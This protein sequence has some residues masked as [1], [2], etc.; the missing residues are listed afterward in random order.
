MKNSFYVGWIYTE[1]SLNGIFNTHRFFI[2]RLSENFNKVVFIDLTNFKIKTNFNKVELNFSFRDKVRYKVPKNV[3]FFKPKTIKELQ[4][5]LINKNFVS[6]L[7]LGRNFSDFKIHYI[8]SKLKMKFV[9][10]SYLGNL[11]TKQIIVK[12]KL[13]SGIKYYL[14]KNISH[15][16]IV[17]FSNFGIFPKLQI[18]F[19]TD[20]SI[21][22][23]IKKSF[24]KKIFFKFNLFYAKKFILV[25]SLFYDIFKYEKNNVSEKYIVLLDTDF[26]HPES[27]SIR[28]YVDNFVIYEHYKKL[29]IL[30][31]HFQKL[32]KK[33]IFVSI[34]PKSNLKEKK[35]LFPDFQVTKYKTRDLIYNSKL[36]LF[37]ESSAILDAVI[38]KKP[39]ITLKSRHLDINSLRGSNDYAVSL[40]I[41][42]LD[43]DDYLKFN[44]KLNKKVIDNISNYHFYLNN[45]IIHDKK[46][47][48]YKKIINNI[49]KLF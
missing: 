48:G 16:L 7:N 38:L 34:H 45:Y 19:M 1:H 9:Q 31:K 33:K 23:S 20:K 27:V 30:L 43:I 24:F 28:G 46:N 35:L 47:F 13:C 21:L 17:F 18:R 11:Q 40:G 6:I 39:I 10:I 42:Q 32:F 36:V 25:N 37:F 44:L 8:L 3:I 41:M 2:N 4:D 49:K 15:K 29:N 5:F 22:E 14:F 12:S 26:S